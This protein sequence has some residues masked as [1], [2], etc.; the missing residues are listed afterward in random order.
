MYYNA[1]KMSHKFKKQSKV[2]VSEDIKVQRFKLPIFKKQSNNPKGAA[3]T[4][5]N[6]P[7]H[8]RRKRIIVSLVV[9]A[10]LAALV[11][12]GIYY[13]QRISNP[14]IPDGR[15]LTKQEKQLKKAYVATQD[16]KGTAEID[17]LINNAKDEQAKNDLIYQK[18]QLCY[19]TKDYSCSLQAYETLFNSSG[20]KNIEFGLN[21]MESAIKVKD[22]AKAKSYDAK[23]T[24]LIAAITEPS[25]KVTLQ[26]DLKNLE[27]QLNG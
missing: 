13:K 1:L 22:T 18:A 26:A 15:K 27:K 10:V 6:E 8:H 11:A 23:L 25:I 19:N 9:V 4:A 3:P 7:S 24:V 17:R 2:V 16:G 5:P 14:G 12:G 20:Q 21:A